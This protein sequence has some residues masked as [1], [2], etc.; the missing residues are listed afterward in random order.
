MLDSLTFNEVIT[1]TGDATAVAG[2]VYINSRNPGSGSS[3]I[4]QLF[5]PT[6]TQSL[7]GKYIGAVAM[8]LDSGDL[9]SGWWLVGHIDGSSGSN[10]WNANGVKHCTSV[11]LWCDGTT[12]R[13]IRCSIQ[14]T[15][16]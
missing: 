8:H 16:G 13:V 12:W 6:P 7:R 9:K 3:Q 5:L 10:I 15:A 4:R 14:I 11:L 2:N 1:T